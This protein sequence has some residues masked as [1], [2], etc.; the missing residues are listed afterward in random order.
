MHAL[1][2]D[3]KTFKFYPDIDV[4]NEKEQKNENLPT[5]FKK[6]GRLWSRGK[7]L[8]KTY[9]EHIGCDTPTDCKNPI[10][11]PNIHNNWL[12]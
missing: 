1:F 7:H 5:I 10:I 4:W 9:Q 3:F 12:I 11:N 6:N 2:F 8:K